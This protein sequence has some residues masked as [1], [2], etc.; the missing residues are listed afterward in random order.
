M[1]AWLR[2]VLLPTWKITST[3]IPSSKGCSRCNNPPVIESWC[4]FPRVCRP[5]SRR[6]RDR[7]VPAS[8][9]RGARNVDFTDA[10][11]AILYVRLFHFDCS[12]VE[13][14]KDP[15]VFL[16]NREIGHARSPQGPIPWLGTFLPRLSVSDRTLPPLQA[17]S[18]ADRTRCS[19]LKTRD[20]DRR[21]RSRVFSS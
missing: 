4:S 7:T 3:L 18:K 6:T 13:I 19:P 2:T 11:L 21:S 1:V 5:F 16:R 12:G 9:T 10:A 14:T 17:E 20:P 8:F 15:A